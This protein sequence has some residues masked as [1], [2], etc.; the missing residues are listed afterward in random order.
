MKIVGYRVLIN[1]KVIIVRHVDIVEENVNLIGFKDDDGEYDYQDGG[2]D[3]NEGYDTIGIVSCKLPSEQ[4]VT[5]CKNE[6]EMVLKRSERE[7]EKPDKYGEVAKYSNYIYVNFISGDTP[8]SYEK[9]VNSGKGGLIRLE[10]S[11]G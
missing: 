5:N 10:I 8:T 2:R 7:R 11:N 3:R 1:N 4:K 9:A 6:Q